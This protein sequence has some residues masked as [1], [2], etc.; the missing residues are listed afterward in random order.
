MAPHLGLPLLSLIFISLPII[1]VLRHRVSSWVIGHFLSRVQFSWER[2]AAS[3]KAGP[4]RG[5]LAMSLASDLC[6]ECQCLPHSVF[7]QAK[8]PS[9]EWAHCHIG[10]GESL[11]SPSHSAQTLAPS[12]CPSREPRGCQSAGVRKLSRAGGS[13]E[14][15]Q[16]HSEVLL[17]SWCLQFSLKRHNAFLNKM[18][19]GSKSEKQSPSP[20]F[21]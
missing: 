10:W 8:A 3:S 19:Y 21:P 14:H 4:P 11:S 5:C 12:Q 13:L 7:F 20:S 2:A 18:S 1:S 6:S 9:Q 16:A 15:T 17:F